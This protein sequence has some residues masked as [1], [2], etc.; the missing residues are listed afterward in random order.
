MSEFKKYKTI[1]K[2]QHLVTSILQFGRKTVCNYFQALF[3]YI[4]KKG[5]Y[6]L[7]H[8]NKIKIFI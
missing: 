3:F 8:K 7:V 5:K 4:Q 1:L 2:G 6:Y